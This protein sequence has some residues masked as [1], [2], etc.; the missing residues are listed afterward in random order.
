[1][2]SEN[3]VKP[4]KTPVKRRRVT[5]TFEAPYA[6]A[7]S[8]MGDFNQWDEKKHPMKKGK[9]GLWQKIIMVQPGRYGYR[10]LVD[11]QWRND[12]ANDQICA[13]YFGSTNN[14]LEVKLFPSV[15]NHSHINGPPEPTAPTTGA[16]GF[17]NNCHRTG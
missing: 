7:V 6:E 14:I 10:F 8:L 9:Q 4:G 12:P 16:V 11:G 2:A 3:K 1:M 15:R 13:N 5:M 17:Q